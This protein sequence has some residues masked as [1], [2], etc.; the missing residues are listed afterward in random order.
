MTPPKSVISSDDIDH[1]H[2]LEFFVDSLY[3]DMA[4]S[5]ALPDELDEVADDWQRLFDWKKSNVNKLEKSTVQEPLKIL[6]RYY[7]GDEL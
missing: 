2:I 7:W 5:G 4:M 6:W 3:E 1:L